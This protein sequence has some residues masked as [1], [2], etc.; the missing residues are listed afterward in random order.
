MIAFRCKPLNFQRSAATM[1]RALNREREREVSSNP[2]ASLVPPPTW[3]LSEESHLLTAIVSKSVVRQ[4]NVW[5]L[6]RQR[7]YC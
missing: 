3:R 7:S 6:K 4:K 2:T 5:S 1:N